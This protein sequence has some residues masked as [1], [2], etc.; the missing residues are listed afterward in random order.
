VRADRL[1]ALVLLLQARGRLTAEELAARLEVSVRTIY[2]DLD[3]LSAAGVP[4][5]AVSGRGGGV[6]LPAGYRADLTALNPEEA[7]ALFLGG[8]AAP[9]A[10]LGVGRILDAALRKLSAALPAGG[11][12]ADRARQR[13]LVDASDWWQAPPEPRDPPAPPDAPAPP[14]LRTIEEAVW[15]DRRLR[16]TYAR[17]RRP[18]AERLLDPYALVAKQGVW[19]LV[20]ADA[21]ARGAALPEPRVFRVSRVQA[22]HVVDEPSRRREAFD[23][24]RFWAAHCRAFLA[25]VPSYLVTLRVHPSL[26]PRMVRNPVKGWAAAGPA[27][28]PDAAGW[29]VMRLDMEA[30]EVAY[31]TVLGY[32]PLL[33]VLEPPE[34]RQRI[35]RAATETA[36]LYLERSWSAG[37]GGPGA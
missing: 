35:A 15:R 1:I 34:L 9:L 37:Q 11:D 12:A 25:S 19:Y 29:T 17:Y 5:Y 36:G 32:G 26:A 22:A 10:E 30:P 21:A 14:H 20:A 13:L 8:A 16:L 4:V 7:R 2:R 28:E 18:A 3:A 24:P 23:L 27:G 33:E 31:G 6:A